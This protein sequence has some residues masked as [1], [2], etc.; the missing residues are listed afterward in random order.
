MQK[1]TKI[2]IEEECSADIMNEVPA[3]RKTI[4]SIEGYFLAPGRR[5][6]LARRFKIRLAFSSRQETGTS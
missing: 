2:K 1:R 4:I 5:L 3:K 6:A